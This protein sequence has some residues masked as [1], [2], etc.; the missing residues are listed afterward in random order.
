MKCERCQEDEAT[1][2][3]TQVVNGAV[4]KLHLCEDC[5]AQSGVDVHNPMSMAELLLG[6]GKGAAADAP[7]APGD[8]RSC[9]RCHLRGAD[10]RKTGRLGCPE[11]Y[12]AFRAELSPLIRSMHRKERHAGKRPLGAAAAPPPESARPAASDIAASATPAPP[13]AAPTPA[14]EETPYDSHPHPIPPRSLEQRRADLQAELDEA[15]QREDF[16]LAALLRD[17]MRKLE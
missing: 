12:T 7:A 4:K 16:E 15:V 1:V 6:F 9:P 14:E 5:A 17:E 8:A 2:H 13:P 3:L 10:F 11:C